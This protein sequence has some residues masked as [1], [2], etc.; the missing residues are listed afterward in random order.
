MYWTGLN[1]VQWSSDHEQALRFARKWDA[2]TVASNDASLRKH[3]H[4]V[5]E[6]GWDD[7]E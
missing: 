4:R 6:H 2:E 3:N 7:D 1:I 5:C